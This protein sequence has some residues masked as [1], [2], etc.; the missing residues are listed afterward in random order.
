MP[1]S[2]A[3]IIADG[4]VTREALDAIMRRF[5][6]NGDG[7]LQGEEVRDF[8][9]AVAP[10]V[11]S[12]MEDLLSILDFYQQDDDPDLSPEEIQTFLEVHL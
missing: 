9:R 4:R 8:A 3:D 7:Q 6:T 10:L 5:D 1:R 2:I 12:S 11:Q